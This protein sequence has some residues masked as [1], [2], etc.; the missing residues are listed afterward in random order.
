MLLEQIQKD[1]ITAMK[2][3]DELTKDTLRMAKSSIDSKAKDKGETLTDTEVEA[4]LTT[5]IKQRKDSFDQFRRGNRLDLAFKEEAE[6]KLLE[7]YLPQEA[8]EDQLVVAVQSFLLGMSVGGTVISPKL[9]GVVIKGVKE[10]LAI[11]N[12]RADGK[13]LSTIVKNELEKEGK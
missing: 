8:S 5:L 10:G 13:L 9:M 4:V 6:F 1:I 3:K 7:K 2:A 12:L 11:Q